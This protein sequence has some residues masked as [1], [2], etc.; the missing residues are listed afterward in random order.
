MKL[1]VLANERMKNYDASK[2]V[3]HEDVMKKYDVT[4]FDLIDCDEI[5]FE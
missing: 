5:E 4:A 1:L 3:S 2:L